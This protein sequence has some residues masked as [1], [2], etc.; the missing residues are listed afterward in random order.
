[1][2]GAFDNFLYLVSVLST[3][4]LTVFSVKREMP[5]MFFVKLLNYNQTLT[6][7][8]AIYRNRVGAGRAKTPSFSKIT[9][10]MNSQWYI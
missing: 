2:T 4:L 5:S 7:P 3:G 9:K 10:E 1:M 6:H 8:M